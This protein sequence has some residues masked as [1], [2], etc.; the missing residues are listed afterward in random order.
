MGVLVGDVNGDAAVNA[1]M[2][3]LTKSQV[4]PSGFSGSRFPRRRR[5]Q[6]PDQL[7][8]C[9]TG[10]I[11]SRYRA[12]SLTAERRRRSSRDLER[13][14]LALF[15]L[16]GSLVPSPANLPA[17]SRACVISPALA[18]STDL[19]HRRYWL[20]PTLLSRSLTPPATPRDRSRGLCYS[21]ARSAS[22]V[23][24]AR[25]AL[26]ESVVVSL[27]SILRATET[28]T[29]SLDSL[30]SGFTSPDNNLL[31]AKTPFVTTAA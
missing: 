18:D 19:G 29:T 13:C 27:P 15:R 12:A 22:S 21:N 25:G 2:S 6:W 14:R 30:H 20:N 8:G 28:S 10:Q 16:T 26:P 5:R 17:Q 24:Q 9:R 7:G 31:V 4:G 23:S 11:Q 1:S 3:S